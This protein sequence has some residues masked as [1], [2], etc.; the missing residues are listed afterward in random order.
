MNGN[1]IMDT[2]DANGLVTS[3][4]PVAAEQEVPLVPSLGVV[5]PVPSDSTTQSEVES[6]SLQMAAGMSEHAYSSASK[7]SLSE[8]MY[9]SFKNCIR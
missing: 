7:L 3:V 6:D 8:Y 5:S 9:I 1:V 2:T 4:P